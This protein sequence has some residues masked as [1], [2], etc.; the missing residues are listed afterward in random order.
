MRCWLRSGRA[1]VELP[2]GDYT[3]DI[4]P[5][6]ASEPAIS[7]M[8]SLVD[9]TDYSVFAIGDGINQELGILAYPLGL[10]PLRDPVD[11]SANGWWGVQEGSGVGFIMQPMPSQNRLIGT[12]YSY[13]NMGSPIFYTFDSAGGAFDDV[14]A[15]TTLYLSTGGGTEDGLEV[16]TNAVG[17]IEC[18]ILGCFDALATVTIDNRP[19]KLYT[20]KRL[21][22][23]LGCSFD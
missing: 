11:N 14:M 8:F 16:E 15:E 21:V 23:P 6:G 1:S 17:N 5:V 2:S 13:D 9:G 4:V 22:V 10:L 7:Q 12:W 18:E 19:T 3:I 20:A